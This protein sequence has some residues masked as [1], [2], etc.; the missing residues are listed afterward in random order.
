MG[1]LSSQVLGKRAANASI[2]HGNQAVGHLG[3]RTRL[4]NELGIDVHFANIVHDNSSAY[5]FRIREH[6]IQ[7]RG[8]AGTQITRDHRNANRRLLGGNFRK[9]ALRGSGG[10]DAFFF[11]F[12]HGSSILFRGLYA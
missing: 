1:Q 5:A 4:R 6:V 10:Q 3:H 9:L 2:R 11:R 8:F 7:Q 12:F